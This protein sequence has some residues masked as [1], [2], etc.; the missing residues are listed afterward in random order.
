MKDSNFISI[1]DTT[2]RDGEQTCGVSFTKEEKLLLTKKLLKDLKVNRV[3]WTSAK[4]SPKEQANLTEIMKWAKQNELEGSIEVLSFTDINKSVD[5]L[6]P[7]NCRCLNLL[8]KG[9]LR[10]CEIQLKKTK[11]EHLRDVQET[12][13]YATKSGMSLSVYMEDWSGGMLSPDNYVFYM[14]DAYKDMGFKRIYLADTL[15]IFDMEKVNRFVSEIV[16]KYPTL[17]FEFHG[18]N[19]YGLATANAITALKAGA[20]GLHCTVNGLG[21]RAGNANLAEIAV[22]I[23]DHLGLKTTLNEKKLKEIS[24]LVANFSRKKISSNAPVVGEDVFT[25][26]AGVHADGDKKGNLYA[27]PLL[28]ARFGVDRSYALGKLSGKSNIE[29]NLKN[30]GIELTDEQKKVLLEKVVSLGDKKEII[31]VSDLQFMVR[32]LLGDNTNKKFKV[33][34]C[35]ITSS[36]SMKPFATIKTEYDGKIYDGVGEGNGG[37]DAF[38]NALKGIG[39]QA[40][41]K[42]PKLLDY[43]VH[44][45]SGGMT[46]ALVECVITWYGNVKTHAVSSDQVVAAIFAT[47][48]FMNL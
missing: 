20:K 7:T 32:D 9:S 48:K 36:L 45:P 19:D 31:T 22:N 4:S 17:N 39:K 25:Q 38:M 27:N 47:E 43:E 28:P 35:I 16:N 5:W 1:V 6:L 40:G 10:H 24:N 46:D 37:Y 14:L 30:L 29:M 12:F 11:E 33:V 18:H 2:M 3:E 42:I 8:T 34:E 23:K 44:I 26:T 13:E 21:E 41:F 15:G